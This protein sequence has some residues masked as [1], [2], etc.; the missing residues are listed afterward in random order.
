MR[1]EPILYGFPGSLCSQKV[2]LALAEKGVDYES[3]IVD[4]EL[5]MQNYEP[6]YLRL[7][8]RG[9]V[10]TLV[11]GDTVVTDSARIVRYVD[12]HFEGPPLVPADPAERERMDAWI[13]QQDGLGM[14]E[15]SYASFQGALG[16]LLRRVSMPLRQR[17]L[18]RLR[19][20]NPDLA[21]VYDAKLEDVRGWRAAIVDEATIREVRNQT[22]EALRAADQRLGESRHLAGDAYSLADVTWTCVLARLRMLGLAEIF[23]GRG[24][25]PHLADYYERLRARPSFVA[26]GIWE[27]TPRG[28]ERLAL[29]RSMRASA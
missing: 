24:Q 6:A 15:L 11:H 8:P 10:P 26:A 21:E 19:K 2:R 17:K 22:A 18:R 29:I 9:V 28:R 5:R 14:R 23:F 20:E 16:L 1:A 7:N 13:R 4:I 12:E 27:A 25:C 3:R